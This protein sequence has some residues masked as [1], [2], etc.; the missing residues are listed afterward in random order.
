MLNIPGLFEEVCPLSPKDCFIFVER[1]KSSFT[2]PLHVHPEYELNY[3]EN[4]KGAQ[5]TVGDSVEEIGAYD[6]AL[7]A[8]PKLEHAWTDGC[9]RSDDIYEVTIQFHRD[10]FGEAAL[11]RNQLLSIRRL[12]DKARQGV[13]FSQKTIK[14]VVPLLKSLRGEKDGFTSLLKFFTILHE[15]SKDE[16]SRLLSSYIVKENEPVSDSSALNAVMNYLLGHYREPI[17]VVE[18]AGMVSMSETSFSRFIKLHTGR[19]FVDLLNDIRLGEATRRLVNTE[20]SIAEIAYGCGF[21]NL[22]NFNRTF[23]R[24]KGQTPTEFR[25]NY[26]KNRVFI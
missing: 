14:K 22:S 18:V 6:M 13:V 26:R 8:N 19:T 15:L 11:E 20:E 17:H 23:K 1:H 7:I 2:F 21:N 24:K 4:A 12:F 16:N 9:C 3:V 10:L 25:M 5:R